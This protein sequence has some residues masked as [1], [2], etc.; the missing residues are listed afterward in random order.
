MNKY[1]REKSNWD[2]EYNFKHSGQSRFIEKVI[3]NHDLK[4]SK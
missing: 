1:S 3:L 4:M 2:G